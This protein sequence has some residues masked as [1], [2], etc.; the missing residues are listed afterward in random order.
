[1][2]VHWYLWLRRSLYRDKNS[3][4]GKMSYKEFVWFLLSEEDKTTPR[5]LACLQGMEWLPVVMS[6]VKNNGTTPSLP[7]LSSPLPSPPRG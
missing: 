1:M 7:L 6:I 3:V 2:C 5:R 4:A